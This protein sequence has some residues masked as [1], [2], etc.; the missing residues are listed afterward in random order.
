MVSPR[1]K[2]NKREDPRTLPQ[3]SENIRSPSEAAKFEY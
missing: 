1:L 3:D 2:S